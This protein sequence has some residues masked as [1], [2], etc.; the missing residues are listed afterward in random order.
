MSR[1]GTATLVTC[2]IAVSACSGPGSP[3]SVSPPPRS[4]QPTKATA[5]AAPTDLQCRYQIGEDPPPAQWSVVLGVA[6]LPTSPRAQALQT[7]SSG[8]GDP[9]FRLFAKTG[10]VIRAGAV[11]TITVRDD[12]ADRVSIGWGGAPAQPRKHVSVAGCQPRTS[13]PAGW[14]NFVGGFWVTQ[15]VCAPILVDAKGRQEQVWFGL[16]RPCPEQQP[17]PNPSDR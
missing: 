9:K 1:W 11:F 15:P 17:P 7:S 4:T 5:N 13:A 2:L 3:K 12:Y 10:L 8:D 6:A 16:G 14:L